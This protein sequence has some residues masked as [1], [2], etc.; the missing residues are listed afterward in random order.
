MMY[1][2]YPQSWMLL[3]HGADVNLAKDDGETPLAMALS[4]DFAT[5]TVLLEARGATIVK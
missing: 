5:G 4:I 1:S 2:R 3:E